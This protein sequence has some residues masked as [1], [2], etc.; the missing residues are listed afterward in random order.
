MTG[1]TEK[2]RAIKKLNYLIMKLN[3]LRSTAIEFEE[4][5]KY[6]DKLIEKLEASVSSRKKKI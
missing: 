2:Y 5:Q 6:S 4:P 1:A 3:T